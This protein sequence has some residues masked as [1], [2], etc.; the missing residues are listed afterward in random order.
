MC[1]NENATYKTQRKDGIMNKALFTYFQT[2]NGDTSKSTAQALGIAACTLSLRLNGK[3]RGFSQNDIAILRKR[4]NLTAEQC[5]EI[6]L[7]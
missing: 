3:R 2:I 7:Q 4:W 1:Y 6:F 5:A